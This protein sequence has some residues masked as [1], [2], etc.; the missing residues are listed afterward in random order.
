MP[1]KKEPPREPELWERVYAR[2]GDQLISEVWYHNRRI[3]D[4]IVQD[5]IQTMLL[6]V[7]RNKE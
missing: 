2:L 5:L 4:Q 6:I 3:A 1:K 7:E